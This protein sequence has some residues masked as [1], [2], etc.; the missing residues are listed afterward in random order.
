MG[1]L[2]PALPARDPGMVLIAGTLLLIILYRR[3]RTRRL[4]GV[5]LAGGLLAN[6]AF[7]LVMRGSLLTLLDWRGP[8]IALVTIVVMQLL[9]KYDYARIPVADLRP[10]MILSFLTILG[11][12][13]SRIEG[14]P[15]AT[16]ETT[17]SRLTAEEV[18]RIKAWGTAGPAN[19]HVVIVSHVPFAP[20]ILVGSIG[21]VLLAGLSFFR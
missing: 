20:F 15:A 10:G 14:L 6:I 9:G 21:Y 18:G 12:R 17:S 19:S 8:L 13:L 7:S 16:T 2:Y 11:F 4:V 3:L 5:F 1:I